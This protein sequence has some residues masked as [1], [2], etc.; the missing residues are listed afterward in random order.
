MRSKSVSFLLLSVFL[1]AAAL[2]Q[3]VQPAETKAKTLSLTLEE[4]ILKAMKNNLGVAVQVLEPQIAEA[5]LSRAGEKF[6]PSLSFNLNR[7]S[8]NSASYS[9]IDAAEKVI[10]DYDRYSTQINQS[11]PTGGSLDI[12][13]DG[14]KN[15]TNQKFQTI[16]PRFGSTLTFNL[17]QPLLKDF[18]P[19]MSRREISVAR[20]NLN[21][22]ESQL[23]KTLLDTVYEVEDSYWNLAYYI[24]NLEIRK[25]SLT[26]ARDLLEKNKRSVEVGTLAPIEIL[27]AQAEVATREADILQAEA[28][29]KNAEDRLKVVINLSEEEEKLITAIIPSDKASFSEKTT[30][31]DEALSKAMANRPDLESVRLGLKNQE[32]NVSYAKNQ[33]LPSLNLSASYWSPGVSGNRILYLNDNPLTG[34]IL[35]IL[36]GGG[37]AALKDAVNFRYRNWSLGLTLS[38]PLSNVFSR[39]AYAQAKLDMQQA[40]LSLKEQEQS[41]FLEVKTAVRAVDTNFKRIQAY[42]VARELAEQKMTAE[43]EKLKVGLSTN[44]MVLTY[45]REL[46]TART[47]ELRA[48]VDYNLSLAALDRATGV[49][50]ENKNI[51]FSEFSA[52]R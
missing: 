34:V 41:V 3:A 26:L 27:S 29:V 5:S 33:L 50:L 6:I 17:T 4:C 39:A 20:N 25:L 12:I 40:L 36:P 11:L 9:W 16:N 48:I 23:R 43:E 28:Q 46:A 2:G 19:K 51:K 21:I 10:T 42:K 37:S 8:T 18:G 15:D 31:L 38:V 13:L 35:G 1:T 49:T 7:R 30:S 24:D 45:Q 32:I 14:Y 47:S 52:H 44:F 22:S